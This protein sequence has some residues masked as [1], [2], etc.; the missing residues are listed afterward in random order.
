MALFNF[1]CFVFFSGYEESSE[2]D[3]WILGVTTAPG[4]PSPGP[5]SPDLAVMEDFLHPPSDSL[6]DEHDDE[7][8]SSRPSNP[9]I[10]KPLAV[11]SSSIPVSRP[12]TVTATSGRSSLSVMKPAAHSS[13]SGVTNPP[14]NRSGG[15]AAISSPSV[16]STRLSGLVANDK[17]TKPVSTA[18]AGVHKAYV[19]S[20]DSSP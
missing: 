12:G 16:S 3:D 20:A 15:M 10:S 5:P 9:P 11:S 4:P 1:H 6:L 13:T 17:P 14:A 8:Q 2:Y 18:N 19:V 7:P